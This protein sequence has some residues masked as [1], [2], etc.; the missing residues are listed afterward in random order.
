[1]HNSKSIRSKPKFSPEYSE[2]EIKAHA[3]LEN[4]KKFKEFTGLTSIPPQKQYWTLCARQPKTPGAEIIQLVN[5]GFLSKKQFYGVDCDQ[6]IIDL[7][8]QDHPEAN[9]FCGQWDEVIEDKSFD[10]AMVYLDTTSLAGHD[11]A[12]KMT[13]STMLLVRAGTLLA[14]NV[15]LNNPRSKESFPQDLFIRFLSREFPSSEFKHW[16]PKFPNYE[17]NATGRTTMI[18]YLL[19]KHSEGKR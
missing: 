8:K 10:P 16:G 17:Y 4:I 9:W 6:G 3:R 11:V 18:T 1:M 19:F 7:N 13:V 5:E 2:L 12:V 15:M 14:V